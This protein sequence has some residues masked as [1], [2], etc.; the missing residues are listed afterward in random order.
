MNRDFNKS[1]RYFVKIKFDYK[2]Y[3]ENRYKNLF[4]KKKINIFQ[5][6]MCFCYIK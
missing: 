5:V 3:I 1:Q 6:Q 2:N 4:N